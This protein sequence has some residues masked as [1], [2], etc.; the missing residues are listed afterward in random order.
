VNLVSEQQFQELA[1][2]LVSKKCLVN[3]YAFLDQA[4]RVR[5]G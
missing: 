2:F 5:S 4:V 3:N 1:R